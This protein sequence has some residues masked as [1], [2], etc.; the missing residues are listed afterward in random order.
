MDYLIH[1]PNP[2]PNRNPLTRNYQLSCKTKQ[3]PIA[4][5]AMYNKTKDT[6]AIFHH[7]DWTKPEPEPEPEPE[8]NA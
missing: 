2:N 4:L 7:I 1:N 8:P 5:H 3:R 6:R